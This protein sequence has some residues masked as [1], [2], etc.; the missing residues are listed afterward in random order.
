MLFNFFKK[1]SGSFDL[2]LFVPIF[3][4]A[5]A[6]I[7]TMNSFGVGSTLFFRQII[8]LVISCIFLIGASLIDWS[9][10]RRSEV[11]TALFVISC[12]VLLFFL[13]CAKQLLFCF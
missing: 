11:V 9:F 10:L 1:I 12:L 6:G 3:F 13:Y 4:I 8:W 5:L 2:V 7:L